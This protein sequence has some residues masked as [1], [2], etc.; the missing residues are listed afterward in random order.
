MTFE[1]TE[2]KDAIYQS[3]KGERRPILIKIMGKTGGSTPQWQQDR[4]SR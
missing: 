2:K 1:K 4:F 3:C